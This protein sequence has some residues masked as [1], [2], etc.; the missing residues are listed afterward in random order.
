MEYSGLLKALVKGPESSHSDK[1]PDYPLDGEGL[2]VIWVFLR[3]Y[4]F[5]L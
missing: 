4:L 1:A 5:D 3:G 2:V